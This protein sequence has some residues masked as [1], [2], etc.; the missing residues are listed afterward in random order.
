MA[1]NLRWKLLTILA[2]EGDGSRARMPGIAAACHGPVA[3][4]GSVKL[5][6]GGA[7]DGEMS[8]PLGNVG[9]TCGL[10]RAGAE[11]KGKDHISHLST[12]A[13]A[14]CISV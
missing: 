10:G 8:G 14:C 1:K 6:Q 12:P 9:G 2:V 7:G 5:L 3:C 13:P 4:Q 11:D